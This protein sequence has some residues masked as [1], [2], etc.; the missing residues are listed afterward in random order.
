MKYECHV[1]KETK[2]ISE[3]SIRKGRKKFWHRCHSCENEYIKNWYRNLSREKQLIKTAKRN[4]KIKSVPFNIE[5]HEIVI[6]DFCPVF[7]TAI[8]K[9]WGLDRDNGPSLDRIIP[10]KGYV[11]GNVIV[12]S[13]RANR[14]KGEATIDEMRR[15]S[16]FYGQFLQTEKDDDTRG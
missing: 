12:V 1:C 14:L 4:A 6:P 11:K 5:I 13:W 10:E 15:L 16:S 7:G 2:A 9:E 3:F 8:R